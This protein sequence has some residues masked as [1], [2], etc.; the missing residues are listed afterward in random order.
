MKTVIRL[1]RKP[2]VVKL[3]LAVSYNYKFSDS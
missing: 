1:L 3:E 2:D